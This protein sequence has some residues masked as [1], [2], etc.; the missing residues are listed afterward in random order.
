M[1]S[2]DESRAGR[3]RRGKEGDG[4][5]RRSRS[6]KGGGE[7][8]ENGDG[9]G[10]SDG[11]KSSRDRS[12]GGRVSRRGKEEDD[13]DGE[14]ADDDKGRGARER[15]RA[16]RRS[17]GSEEGG[18]EEDTGD[19]KAD[20]RSRRGRRKGDEN[21]DSDEEAKEEDGDDDKKIPSGRGKD[22]DKDGEDDT[23][24]HGEDGGDADSSRKDKKNKK[25][26]KKTANLE[27]NE[28]IAGRDS[29]MRRSGRGARPTQRTRKQTEVYPEVHILGQVVG[30]TGFGGGGTGYTCKWFIDSGRKWELL[31]GYLGG[32]TQTEYPW[33]DDDMTLWAHPIDVHFK[34]SSMQGWPRI[35]VQVWSVDSYGRSDL[36]ANGF[37]HIPAA[38]SYTT[39]LLFCDVLLC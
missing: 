14:D 11:K 21:E 23:D 8:G 39:S 33:A 35:L 10:G 38:V 32:Q 6:S 19:K 20:R 7:D 25:K 26:G 34:H 16:Q 28:I 3:R 13:V 29:P 27:D 9:T 17:K 15:R 31:E 2:G 5:S 12:R 24:A 30:G 37:G 22:T 1:Q 36:I 18:E 4:D